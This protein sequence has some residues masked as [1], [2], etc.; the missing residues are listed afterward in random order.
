MIAPMI[1]LFAPLAA[2][3]EQLA[4]DVEALKAAQAPATEPEPAPDPD[5]QPE[6]EP[7][8]APAPEPEP[9]PAPT[10]TPAPS[11]AP[12]PAPPNSDAPR[13]LRILNLGR[14]EDGPYLS[15]VK[16]VFRSETGSYNRQD[17]Y[18]DFSEPAL[19]EWSWALEDGVS[20]T[21]RARM[22]ID[23]EP[24]TDWLAPD[25][26]SRPPYSGSGS[27]WR[28]EN[29]TLPR[30]MHVAHVELD[31][32]AAFR[33][34]GVDFSL[35]DTAQRLPDEM[36]TPWTSTMRFEMEYTHASPRAVQVDLSKGPAQ[37]PRK[38]LK[39]RTIE[40][41]TD[42]ETDKSKLWVRAIT[43]NIG[44]QITRYPAVSMLG[45]YSIVRAQK[46]FHEQA[47]SAPNDTAM[48]APR[49]PEIDG[50]RGKL[51]HVVDMRVRSGDMRIYFYTSHMRLGLLSYSGDVLTEFGPYLP[52]GYGAHPGIFEAGYQGAADP[53]AFA[54]KKKFYAD[55]FAHVGDESQLIASSKTSFE[56]WG[57]EMMR[58]GDQ[59]GT[60]NL[61]DAHE[62]WLT[63][64]RGG[65]GGFGA[66]VF[67][68]HWTA[69]SAA[70]FQPAHF[71]PRG[72]VQAPARTGTSTYCDFVTDHPSCRNPWSIRFRVQDQKF[73]WSNIGGHSFG[74]CNIDGS[75]PEIFVISA[76]TPTDAEFGV[77]NGWL[78][79]ST[80][81]ALDLRTQ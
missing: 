9:A 78:R 53:V 61:D 69:H 40:P 42:I 64:T 2:R 20:T 54:A 45:D 10:P 3:L 50:P 23:G 17:S 49:A 35:N 70:G 55:Q 48:P 16:P 30:G 18:A 25:I 13:V 57:F 81:S 34:C 28:F 73:Y 60:F 11:P 59:P 68:D 77:T 4:A 32:D 27:F 75:E 76:T 46:Y 6:P 31:G 19:P 65:A 62:F 29:L 56:G 33:C 47:I 79:A 1:D 22:L 26:G 67:G 39:P 8:P 72:Y 74:R 51:G 58:R 21:A 36:Q 43:D 66:I 15:S 63:R 71:P 14:G 5:P 41:L 7:S 44:L 37:F 38:P 12:E 52:N 24:V 80:R